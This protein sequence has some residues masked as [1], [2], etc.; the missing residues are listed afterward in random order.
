MG[1]LH[2]GIVLNFENQ[3]ETGGPNLYPRAGEGHD[4]IFKSSYVYGDRF[5]TQEIK[6]ITYDGDKTVA[7]STMYRQLPNGGLEILTISGNSNETYSRI[8]TE[9]LKKVISAN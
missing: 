5:G 4:F 6:H 7:Y 3:P 2:S 1:L 9:N 8:T